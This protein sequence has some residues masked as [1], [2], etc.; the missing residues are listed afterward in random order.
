MPKQKAAAKTKKHKKSANSSFS[1]SAMLV[2]L[3][4]AG[5]W[6]MSSALILIIG[7]MPMFVAF[8]VD[9]SPR[10]TKAVTVGAM[11]IAGVTPF[12]MELWTTDHSMD[13]ALTI[14]LDPMAIIVIYS[15][16]AVG[17]IIDWA[18]TLTV[19]SF[20]YQ[21]GVARKKTIEERQ[22]ELIKRWGEEVSGK[23]TLDHEGFPIDDSP[24]TAESQGS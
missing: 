15:A 24:E 18:V 17:Y 14:I 2:L 20:M 13:K 6:F 9:R 16:A 7:L 21:R 12:L 11:N 3:A 1:A 22:A 8:F 10:K 19:A 4:V 23:L 5:V